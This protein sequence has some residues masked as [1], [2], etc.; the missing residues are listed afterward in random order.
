MMQGDYTYFI[1]DRLVKVPAQVVAEMA[2]LRARVREVEDQYRFALEMLWEEWHVADDHGPDGFG[3]KRQTCIE[4]GCQ[5]FQAHLVDGQ[6]LSGYETFAAYKA[7][8]SGEPA[9]RHTCEWTGMCQEDAEVDRTGDDGKVYKVCRT[10]HRPPDP[11]DVVVEAAEE[12]EREHREELEGEDQGDCLC[13]ICLAVRA[14]RAA[15][16]R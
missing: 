13:S 14:L 11:R 9:P 1:G 12:I 8:P 16:G 4:I 15:E 2:A 3:D 5:R 10:L 7:A 6:P